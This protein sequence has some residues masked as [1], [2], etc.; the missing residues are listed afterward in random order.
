MVSFMAKS[1]LYEAIFISSDLPFLRTEGAASGWD[2][3][4]AVLPPVAPAAH[5]VVPAPADEPAAAVSGADLSA[6][7]PAAFW[8]S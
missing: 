2:L 6:P 7:S 8:G 5:P 3:Q 1:L 4:A